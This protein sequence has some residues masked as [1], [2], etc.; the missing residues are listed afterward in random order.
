MAGAAPQEYANALARS[1]HQRRA[2]LELQ[3][4]I[5]MLQLANRTPYSAERTIVL[6]KNGEKSWVVVV[7]ATYR[8]N[9]DG[10]TE[11]ADEQIPPCYSPEYIGEPGQSSLRYEADM[12][13]AKAV[14]DLLLNGHAYAPRGKPAQTVDVQMQVG[15]LRKRLRVFGDRSWASGLLRGLRPTAPVRFERMPIVYERGFG[16][17]DRDSPDPTQQRIYARNPIGTGFATK[18][19]KLKGHALPNVEHPSNLIQRWKQQPLPAG[20]GA[21]ASYWSPR[22]ELAGTYDAA[23]RRQKFPLLP[24]DFD[25]W[26]HQCAPLDQQLRQVRGGEPVSL[27]NL[28]ESGHLA[29]ELPRVH[30]GFRTFFGSQRQEHRGSLQTVIIEPDVPQV[31][32]VWHTSLSCHHLIDRLDQTVIY[33]KALP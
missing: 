2:D 22:L 33:E 4:G 5:G 10:T 6:D 14:T 7:K 32:L 11:L 26:F 20:F 1:Q 9:P 27:E 30:L 24:D 13:P 17:W 8:V 16:G 28:T 18:A 3:A 31:I 25:P 19:R 12:V 23:W 15:A 21:I 29:F